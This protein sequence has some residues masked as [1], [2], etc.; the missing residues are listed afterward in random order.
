MA[1]VTE[2]KMETTREE[3]TEFLSRLEQEMNMGH[4]VSLMKRTEDVNTEETIALVKAAMGSRSMREFA[5][6]MG[7]N[8]SNLSRILSGKVTE[9]RPYTLANIAYEAYHPR[10]TR[11][12]KEAGSGRKS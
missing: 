9:I 4:R 1:E 10:R 5:Q 11:S 8:Q 6:A 2:A 3:G 12:D 7:M